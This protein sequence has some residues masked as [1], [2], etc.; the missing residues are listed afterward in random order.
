MYAPLPAAL[1]KIGWFWVYA[2]PVPIVSVFVPLE[3]AKDVVEV[4]W[5]LSPSP[6]AP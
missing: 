2:K 1:I 3:T 5:Y 4:V 6:V